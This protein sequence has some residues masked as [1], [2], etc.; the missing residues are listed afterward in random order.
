MAT[1]KDVLLRAAEI[2]E[3]E[4]AWTQSWFAKTAE[5]EPCGV[6][7]PS[8]VCWCVSG[9]IQ[10]AS[11]GNGHATYAAMVALERHLRLPGYSPVTFWNDSLQRTQAEAVA[12]L[13]AAAERAQ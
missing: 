10:R 3:P 7:E 11:D 2:I 1:V 6:F 12:A 4:G 13:R 9:A 8:A 5:G